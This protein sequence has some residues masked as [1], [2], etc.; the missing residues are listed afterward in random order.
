MVGDRW[1]EMWHERLEHTEPWVLPWLRHQRRD[2]YWRHASVCEDYSSVACPVLASSGW[3]DGYSN[4]VTR[5]LGHLEVPRK[6]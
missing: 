2:D 3:A 4:A 6:G 5:L 1:R